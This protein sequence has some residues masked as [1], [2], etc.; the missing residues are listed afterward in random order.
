MTVKFLPSWSLHSKHGDSEQV[1]KIIM[2]CGTCSGRGKEGSVIAHM[3][4]RPIL[5]P[6][7]GR[8]F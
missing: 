4:G 5:N 7:G 6:V 1:N 2:D 8:V 3:W